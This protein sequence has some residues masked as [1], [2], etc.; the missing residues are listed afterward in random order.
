MKIKSKILVP[1]ILLTV[2]CGVAVLIS[3]VILHSRELNRAMEGKLNIAMGL[4]EHNISEVKQR[5]QLTAF[6]MSDNQNL[7]EAVASNDRERIESVARA[8]KS[9]AQL[10]FS[11]IVDSDGIVLARTHDPENYGDSIGGA[12]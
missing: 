9:M 3:S 6:A 12:V 1:M 8:M 11:T 2:G 7:S 4:V 5:K 10:D